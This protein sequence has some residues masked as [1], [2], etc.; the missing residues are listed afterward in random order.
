MRYEIERIVFEEKGR[1]ISAFQENPFCKT[2][3]LHQGS[4]A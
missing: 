3:I 2:Q 4:Q 1:R